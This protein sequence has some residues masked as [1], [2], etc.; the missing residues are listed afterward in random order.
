MNHK[1]TDLS[2]QLLEYP[3]A[4]EELQL[5]ILDRTQ[6][7]NKVNE[8]ISNIESKLKAEINAAVDANGKKVYSNAEAREA[9]LVERTKFDANLANLRQEHDALQREIQEARIKVEAMGNQQRNI[10]SI[11]HFFANSSEFADQ[12]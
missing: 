7:V 2:N 12:N 1:L 11:L 9:E 3:Q 6:A 4:I 10:R 5:E 8:Q